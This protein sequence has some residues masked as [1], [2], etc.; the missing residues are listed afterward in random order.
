MQGF[1]R[2]CFRV[3]TSKQ[4][5]LLYVEGRAATASLTLVDPDRVEETNLNSI[6]NAKCEDA[7]STLWAAALLCRCG[8]GER[9][10]LNLLKQAR[11]YWS[12]KTHGNGNVSLVPSV[13]RQKGCRSHLFLRHGRIECCPS[14]SY[15]LGK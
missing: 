10:E 2:T 8:C 11:P 1:T 12:V 5:P 15:P 7:F 9:I 4:W 6:L 14:T 13:C 3:T